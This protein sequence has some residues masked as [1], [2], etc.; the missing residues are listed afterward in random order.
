MNIKI[1]CSLILYNKYTYLKT[2][3]K[4]YIW[5]FTKIFI[6][7]I[8][9]KSLKKNIAHIFI[10]YINITYFSILIYYNKLYKYIKKLYS[11]NIFFLSGYQHKFLFNNWEKIRKL[12]NFKFF[13][14][15]VFSVNRLVGWF[16]LSKSYFVKYK[17]SQK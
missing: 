5:F 15:I 7:Q 13:W 1:L 11:K 17:L 4:I 12:E 2:S 9:K 6:Y 10:V 3:Y 14:P 16:I 8:H